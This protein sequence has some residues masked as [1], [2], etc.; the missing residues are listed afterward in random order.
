MIASN[1]QFMLLGLTI[2]FFKR[3]KKHTLALF[4]SFLLTVALLVSIITLTHTNQ[5]IIEKQNLFIYSDIDYQLENVSADQLKKIKQV[6]GI[7]HLGVTSYVGYIETKENQWGSVIAATDEAILSVSALLD[8]RMPR[9]SDEIVAEKWALL[10]LGINPVVGQLFTLPVADAAETGNKSPRTYRLVGI[11]NDLA[12]NKRSGAIDL[13]TALAPESSRSSVLTVFLAFSENTNKEKKIAAV[14]QAANIPRSQIRKNVWQDEFHQP[15]QSDMQI[16]LLLTFV[17]A[18]VIYGIYRMMLMSRKNQFG[19]LRAIGLTKRQ[20]QKIILYELGLLAAVSYPLGIGLGILLSYLVTHMSKDQ[21]IKIYFWGKADAFQLIVPILPLILCLVL[22]LGATI[23][24]GVI[25]A[26]KVNQ[27]SVIGT[28]FSNAGLEQSARRVALIN[29]KQRFLS[30]YQQL[31]IKYFFQDIKTTCYMLLSLTIG[32]SLFV[33]LSYQAILSNE[34]QEIK[35]ATDFYTSD[36]I[37]TATDDQNS[38]VGITKQTFQAVVNE[39]SVV[40]VDAQTALPIQVVDDGVARNSR[41]LAER[42][43]HVVT[44]YGFQLSGN[45]GQEDVFMTKLKGYNDSALS[46]LSDYLISGK[47]PDD[48][49]KRNEVILAMPTTSTY[50][51]SKG[52]VGFFKTGEPI[53]AYQAGDKIR[54]RYAVG[55]ELSDA[56]IEQ[57]IAGN[58]TTLEEKEWVVSAV[59]FYPYMPQVSL[60]EKSYPL[61]ITSEDN[62]RQIVPQ[63]VYESLAI[64]AADKLTPTAQEKT[65]QRLIELAVANQ[66]VTARSLIDEIAQLESIYRK[67]MVYVIGIACVVFLLVITNVINNLKY[68]IEMR[69]QE[70]FLLKAIGITTNRLIVTIVFENLIVAGMSLVLSALLAIPITRYQYVQSQIYLLGKKYDYPLTSLFAVAF[71]TLFLSVV[72]SWF[73]SRNLRRQTIIE[74]LQ[75]IA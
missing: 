6:S 53:M 17:C 30:V 60:L 31:G 36:F 46:K 7:K 15:L 55:Q 50:G 70:L 20:I 38:Y 61:L 28:I 51:R 9:K 27:Q 63:A 64:H 8:G 72:I 24:I 56:G 71:C 67:E 48:G 23:M 59:V 39:K 13:Y 1:S 29:A 25:G 19:I 21:Q 69:T 33:A 4:F 66:H 42:N 47:I 40:E 37:M 22:L 52:M 57:L 12:L 14:A 43:Q 10:N 26:K 2:R 41:Y 62:F 75:D 45:N 44:H 49:L 5:R 54:T 58:S 3:Y 35:K 16:G 11:I 74:G 32:I 65:E 68:R 73:V 34:E 18:S